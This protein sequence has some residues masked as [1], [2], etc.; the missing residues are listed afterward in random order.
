MKQKLLNGI[1]DLDHEAKRNGDADAIFF[2][3]LEL[4]QNAL[5]V[6]S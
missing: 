6:A 2:F 1:I 4:N 5:T 3:F